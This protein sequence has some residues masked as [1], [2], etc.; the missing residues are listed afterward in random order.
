MPQNSA[1]LGSAHVALTAPPPG[2]PLSSPLHTTSSPPTTTFDTNFLNQGKLTPS[3]TDPGIFVTDHASVMS[4]EVFID[5]DEMDN[6]LPET[7]WT[8]SRGGSPIRSVTVRVPGRPRAAFSSGPTPS[9]PITS[10]QDK[11][12]T[13]VWQ[14]ST[15]QT[16]V[17]EPPSHPN[18][19]QPSLLISDGMILTPSRNLVLYPA[20]TF[21]QM[22]SRTLLEVGAPGPEAVETS[23]SSPGS[24]VPQTSGGSMTPPPPGEASQPPGDVL[25]LTTGS[26]PRVTPTLSQSLQETVSWSTYSAA[27]AQPAP[28]LSSRYHPHLASFPTPLLS[29]NSSA[30]SVDASSPPLLPSSPSEILHSPSV[31]LAPGPAGDTDTLS[32]PRPLTWCVSCSPASPH[33]GPSAS[34]LEKDVGSGDGAETPAVLLLEASSSVSLPSSLVAD[35]S[36]FEEEPQ[37]FNTLF[38]TRPVV[39]LSSRP[40]DMAETSTGVSGQVGVDGALTTLVDPAP[41]LPPTPVTLEA[42]SFVSSSV[43]LSSGTAVLSSVVASAP[44]DAPLDV[45]SLITANK[46]IPSLPLSPPSLSPLYSLGP[47]GE[48][49]LFSDPQPSSFSR[50]E[51]GSVLDFASSFF[52][53]PL[54]DLSS[55]GPPPS[56]PVSSPSP[57]SNDFASQA[58]PTLVETFTL[59]DS[60]TPQPPQ[61]SVPN[62]TD[63]E[64]ALLWP[65]SGLLSTSFSFLSSYSE[66]SP[67]SSIL[68]E[69]LL[70]SEASTVLPTESEAHLTS[71]FTETTSS[72]EFALTPQEPAISTLVL[73]SSE[74]LLTIS[75]ARNHLTSHL[76][77]L[78][79]KPLSTQSS[80]SSTWTPSDDI[81]ALDGHMSTSS[82]FRAISSTVA[83]AS[84]VSPTPAS[85]LAS[86]ASPSAFPTEPVFDNGP[87]LT[88]LT[89]A[90]APGNASAGPSSADAGEAPDS[91]VP[92]TLSGPTESQAPH[93]DSPASPPPSLPPGAT[94]TPEATADTPALLTTKPPYL[95]DITVPDA[96]L[97]TTVLARR[98]VQEYIITSIKEVLRIHFNRAVELQ[99]YELFADFTFLVTSGPFVYTAISVINVLVNSKLVRD[100]TPLILAVKP[101]FLV[102]ESRFQVQTVLQ[103]V[104]PTVDTGFC[105]FTQRM[106]KGLLIALSAVRKRQ[107]GTYNLT[108]QILNVTVASPRAAPWRGPVSIVF[109]VRGSQ[110][111]LSGWEVSEQLRNLTVVE[112]SFYL[113]YPVLQIAEPFQYPQLNLSQLLKSS[114]VRTVLLGVVEKQFQNEVFQAEMERKLA[115][116]LGEASTRRRMWRRATVAAGNS[117]VQVV[118][119]SRLEGDDNPVQ[120]IYFVED[121]DGERLSAV[122]SSD[123]INRID[124]QRAAIIL[125]FRIQ[126]AVAQPVDRVKR[127]SPESQ[128]S[129]LWVIVGVVIPVL[130]VMVIVV[131]LY[132]KLCR[133]DKLDFQPDTVANIQQRQKLQIPSVK[134]FD[135]AKQHLG[136]HSKDDILI[137]HEPAPLPGPG[138]DHTTPSENGDVPSP[139]AKVA[140]KTVRHRGRVSPSDAD[141]TVSEESSEREAG[142]K[143]LGVVPDG[144][145]HRA[146]Q[147]G[148]PAPS[149]GTEQHSSASIF[150]HV[151]RISRSSEASRRVPS[152]IQLIAMQPIAAP[153]LQHPVLADRVAETNKINKEI[154]TALRHKSEIEHHRNKIRLR[155]KRRGH[156]EFPVVDDLSSG[157]TREHHRVYRR[158]QLQIDK[159]LD[160][161]ASVPS[162]FI[163]PRKSSRIKRSPK[164]RRKHQ[165]NG[166]PG[167]AEKDRL[168][169]TD[170]DG[171][172][173]RPPGVHNSAYIG[174]PSDPDL[175]ADAQTP[176]SAELGRYPGL[177]FPAPQYIPPQPSIE[178]ARQ[179]MHSLLDDA[180][181]LVAPSSQPSSASAAGPGGPAGLPVNST[182]SREERRATQWGS[183]YSPVQTA[184]NAG[185]RYEDF[186]MTP[187][188]GP[189]PRPGFGP[190]LLQSSELVPS[191][192]PQAPA[193]APYAARGIY[194]EEMP[195]VARPRPV[196]GTTGTQIQ[197]LTQVGIAS[198]VGAQPVEI[199]AGRGGQ[200]GGPGWPPYG[201]EEAG[202][203]DTTHVLGQ[204]EFSSSPLFQVPR[205]SGREPS[206]PPGNAP[207][208]GLQGSGLAY[209]TSSTEDLQ[210][211]HSSASLIKAIREELLRLSQ[212]QTPVQN[213]HS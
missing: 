100:Q 148:P 171:T 81:S 117:V 145:A 57:T 61:F 102:P 25:A 140:S 89:P 58:F 97:I 60:I 120:L 146:P 150:E 27:G 129:N 191:E 111:L 107:P 91:A 122:K 202:R 41:G 12:V 159:V 176:S 21:G 133:T 88:S 5:D 209:P 174:C 90:P 184:S 87:S 37:V 182:P 197:H 155:A 26:P 99:V 16:A 73:P 54:L 178:E 59:S 39:P 181:A 144:K 19:S 154:Q 179:T 62:S 169:T 164:P 4:N 28:T 31:T 127:P 104:P 38:P 123:L 108:V 180:F 205:T 106:E 157:D 198:R 153:P 161:T 124:I 43:A 112:F 141:S 126:G 113:G 166:C 192:Q 115:Q 151:D 95:C 199:P 142:D 72:F 207:R 212:K 132:W 84:T 69:S 6:F 152:K 17:D 206:A 118:N 114:W 63:L 51:T 138:K 55:S 30:P 77:A 71:A 172:Y 49:S 3:T 175:P 23:P 189:L 130:V 105:N 213:F 185:G 86:E 188:S 165:V 52:S 47:S 70:V 193:E 50:H 92:T 203:R 9:L 83:L 128:S 162:V 173:K 125:G 11:D 116:L 46:I 196:G 208:R 24:S 33:H 158:A 10:V 64:F 48:S 7:H 14:V 93:E 56:L 160:P 53:T 80:L 76:T 156:Y 190:G 65:S 75:T 204:Q 195:P 194:S 211:G 143:T 103:F 68:P 134:G 136:Q 78:P 13:S 82:S 109:A 79:T 44:L 29:V 22:S 67:Q 137:I 131:I 170:S 34:L 94:P 139:K 119:V 168:I 101:S 98:A 135:F 74:P 149:S 110:G 96:Y 45:S 167:D 18:T 40:V 85:S 42:P 210:P 36:E 35:F 8:T 187:P 66:F 1:E 147:S 15:Q 20:D 163:E 2:S 183:F 186:G 200:Y 177:P 32:S 121:Q 201:E